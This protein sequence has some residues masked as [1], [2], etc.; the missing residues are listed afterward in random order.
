[1]PLE[2]KSRSTRPLK[3]APPLAALLPTNF[4]LQQI[5]V[6][7]LTLDP[8]ATKDISPDDSF[9]EIQHKH[10]RSKYFETKRSLR[11]VLPPE[12]VGRSGD[13][14]V[15]AIIAR[16]DPRDVYP[17]TGK[18]I[19]ARVCGGNLAASALWNGQERRPIQTTDWVGYRFYEYDDV[20]LAYPETS[21]GAGANLPADIQRLVAQVID[22]KPVA[23][24]QP[25]IW[26]DPQFHRDSVLRNW[27]PRKTS[28]SS[29]KNVSQSDIVTYLRARQFPGQPAPS[30]KAAQEDAKEHFNGR[31]V[32]RLFVRNA[33]DEVYGKQPRGPRKKSAD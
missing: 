18:E 25:P 32:P 5:F 30:Y 17:N 15:D 6:W 14:K 10:F 19:I 22:G 28:R 3:V 27:P 26:L 21:G 23:R 31:N 24:N 9:V 8:A 12:Q 2:P 11:D 29:L 13:P 7:A 16:M 1:M 33:R 20:V 4:T